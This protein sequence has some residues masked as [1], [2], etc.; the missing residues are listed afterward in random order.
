MTATVRRWNDRSDDSMWKLSLDKKSQRYKRSIAQKHEWEER[1]SNIKGWPC[2]VDVRREFG[3]FD[4]RYARHRAYVR[5]SVIALAAVIVVGL[6][7]PVWQ[8]SHDRCSVTLLVIHLIVRRMDIFVFF[9]TFCRSFA[10]TTSPNWRGMK[11]VSLSF[12]IGDLFD[13]KTSDFCINLE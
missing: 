13:R 7:G 1:M 6:F 10:L 5:Q 11:S 12:F 2:D 8:W 9:G 4:V 3:R